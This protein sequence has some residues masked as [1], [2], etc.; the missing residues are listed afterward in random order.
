MDGLIEQWYLA[1]GSHQQI[2]EKPLGGGLAQRE[3]IMLLWGLY[4]V[5]GFPS[6]S[7]LAGK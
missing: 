7:S 2:F 6:D 4:Y 1:P 5:E 3:K